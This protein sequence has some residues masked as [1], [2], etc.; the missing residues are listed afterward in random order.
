LSPQRVQFIHKPPQ[1][2]LLKAYRSAD[3]FIFSS[4]TDTQGIVLAEAMSQ[5]LPVIAVD[6]PGQRDI[7]TND[8]NGFI[9]NSAEEAV[10][11]IISIVQNATLCNK[12][13]SGAYATA[14]RYHAKNTTQQL[15]NFYHEIKT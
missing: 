9:I 2:E 3:L 8:Y 15:I 14:Q 7:V 11:K 5:G 12:L 13:I 1:D 6:G 10:T 4:H